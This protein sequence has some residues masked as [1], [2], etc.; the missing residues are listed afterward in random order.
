FGVGGGFLIVPAL[1]ILIGL[2]M[3][4]AVGTS[5]IAVSLNALWAVIGNLRSGSLDWTLTLLFASGGVAGVLFG[6]RLGRDLPDPTLRRAFAALIVAIA[7]YTFGRSALSF[8]PLL[9]IY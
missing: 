5:L 4:M 6:A 8:I 9:G 7:V 2:P 3:H 1:T